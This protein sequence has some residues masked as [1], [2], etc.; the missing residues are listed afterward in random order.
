MPLSMVRF[1]LPPPLAALP[2]V[3]QPPQRTAPALIILV[4]A[5]AIAP[6]SAVQRPALAPTRTAASL[7]DRALAPV[8]ILPMSPRPESRKS[9]MPS[10]TLPARVPLPIPIPVPVTVAVIIPTPVIRVLPIQTRNP[11]DQILTITQVRQDQIP[12]VRVA[13]LPALILARVRLTPALTPVPDLIPAQ[14]I[15]VPAVIAAPVTAPPQKRLI[16]LIDCYCFDFNIFIKKGVIPQIGITPFFITFFIISMQSK[17]RLNRLP[18][19]SAVL[20]SR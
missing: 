15:L 4:P 16:S 13:V 17:P 9:V 3:V 20:F 14:L 7:R 1:R 18:A 12:P 11:Q 2:A 8:T 6:M 5:P 10:P 19:F